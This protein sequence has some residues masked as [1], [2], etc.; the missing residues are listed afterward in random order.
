[1]KG[2]SK[3]MAFNASAF[4]KD[5]EIMVIANED[6][7]DYE[8]GKPTEPKGT[9]YKCMIVTDKTNYGEGASK[10]NEGEQIIIKVEGK[11]KPYDKF[12]RVKMINPKCNVYGEYR[13]NISITAE[14]VEFSK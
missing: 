2:L 14:D 12:S 13:N 6:W 7:V 9:K 3:F 5:K 8:N 11:A 4:F 10:L 1:M